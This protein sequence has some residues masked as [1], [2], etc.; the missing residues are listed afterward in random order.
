MTQR[1]LENFHQPFAVL[2]RL[3][4]VPV[5]IRAELGEYLQLAEA[6]KIDAQRTGGLFDSLGLS[7]AADAGY[8]QTDVD[9]RALTG[10]KQV[11]F[12]INLAIGDGNNV[13]R[14]VGGD[15]A[16]SVS[17]IGRA[18]IEPPPYSGVSARALEQAGMQIKHIARICLAAGRAAQQQRQRAV[19]T[20][21]LDR[22]S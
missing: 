18:V 5:Q 9:R 13:G 15:I 7:G 8:R 19:A 1:L 17:M 14:D 2:E 10:K 12:Q 22:S 21:C 4:G 11:I 3:L 16:A 6:G 20:A